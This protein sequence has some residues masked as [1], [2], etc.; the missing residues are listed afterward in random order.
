VT[1][2]GDSPNSLGPVVG[3]NVRERETE[4][5]VAYTSNVLSGIARWGGMVKSLAKILPGATPKE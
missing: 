5:K 4:M 3:G 2:I 1:G